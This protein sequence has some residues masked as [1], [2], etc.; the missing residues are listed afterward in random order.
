MMIN[1]IK[2]LRRW[3]GYLTFYVIA[4]AS[5][6]SVT[7]SRRLF[8]RM[9]VMKLDVAKVFVFFIPEERLYAFTINPELGVDYPT[10]LND[11]QFNGRYRCIGFETL[12]PTVNRIFYDYGLLPNTRCKLSV[13]ACMNKD[14]ITYYKIL[15]P[16]DKS[17]Q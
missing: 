3:L 9:G 13:E 14:G 6:N 7:L 4:D 5:D 11:I 17:N 10:Q 8:R 1:P 16:H 2:Y 15:R 12:C